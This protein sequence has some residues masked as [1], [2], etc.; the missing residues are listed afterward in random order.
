MYNLAIS[1]VSEGL[2]VVITV[3]KLFFLFNLLKEIGNFLLKRG[4]IVM[5]G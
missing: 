3:P 4:S 1:H 5:D 2:S